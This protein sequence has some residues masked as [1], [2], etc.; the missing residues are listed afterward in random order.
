MQRM[1]GVEPAFP[2]PLASAG[3]TPV[4]RDVAPQAAQDFV[5]H[6]PL[7]ETR[8]Q[9]PVRRPGKGRRPA[10]PGRRA[11]G[12]RHVGQVRLLALPS[13]TRCGA[14]VGVRLEALSRR[15]SNG[16]TSASR[17]LHPTIPAAKATR[18]HARQRPAAGRPRSARGSGSPCRRHRDPSQRRPRLGASASSRL[19]RLARGPETRRRGRRSG[20]K[21]LGRTERGRPA[22]C[23]M[24]RRALPACSTSVAFSSPDVESRNGLAMKTRKLPSA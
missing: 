6:E 4:E 10:L 17:R 9:G 1:A 2:Q 15:A 8:D 22:R 5:E 19:I 16:R 13:G 7:V 18:G 24:S 14:L 23:L 21:P 12:L 11:G 20:S 3:R